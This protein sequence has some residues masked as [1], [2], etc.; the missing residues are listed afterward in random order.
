MNDKDSKFL[1]GAFILTAAGF[2]VKVLGALYRIPLYSILGDEGIGLFQMAYPIYA[3]ILTVSSSG[4]NVAISKVVSERW[5]LNQKNAAQKAFKVSLI[6]MMA[7][8]LVGSAALYSLSGWI[9]GKVANDVRA[10]PS[11][12]AISP[13]LFFASIL[14]A[15]RG[16][17][18]GIEEMSPSAVSQVLEQLARMATMFFLARLF[19]P[20]GLQAA[21]AGASAG[22]VA[23][24]AVG[25]FYILFVYWRNSWK[26]KAMSS[27]TSS[28]TSW[29]NTAGRIGRIAVP[30]SLASG[31]SGITQL[32]DLA[33]VP[34]RLQ[35]GGLGREAAT[36]LYGKLTGGAFPLLNITT[37]FTGAL[38][39]ALVPSVSSAIAVGDKE[40]AKR[41]VKKALTFA[42]M[43]ALPAAVGLFALSKE[44]PVL[45]F[46]D[47]DIGPIL[48]TVAPGVLFMAIQQVS[49]GVLQGLGLMDIPLKNL[50]WAAS[51]KA[52][53]TYFFVSVPAFGIRAAGAATTI[54]FGI[55][56]L[57]NIGAIQKKTGNVLDLG[58][59]TKLLLSSAAMGVAVVLTRKTAASFLTPNM[60]T[61]FAIA[62]GVLSYVFFVVLSGAVTLKELQ[63][64]PFIGRIL[65][66]WIHKD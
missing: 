20:S 37:V 33:L 16:W 35:A 28:Y 22:A 21:A 27:K 55:A 63:N 18:Q 57:L 49:S 1:K 7:F 29:K 53:L 42:F 19:I 9:A 50:L 65:S 5:A 61:V 34:G 10:A 13:A 58:A 32:L 44:I 17:F 47:P 30:I 56:A 36:K 26:W 15:L 52:L 51:A 45:L 38:Q 11:I 59:L 8:G 24:A 2:V 48:V 62:A 12:A 40:G 6:I 25:M 41:R 23:G 43:L 66:R 60:A 3:V 39:V 46:K 14:S 64:I 4:L 54:Q 31:A